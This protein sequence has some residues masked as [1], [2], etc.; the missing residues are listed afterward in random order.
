[1]QSAGIVAGVLSTIPVFVLYVN[2]D[3]VSILL[4]AVAALFI[5]ELD[6]LAFSTFF[7]E[8]SKSYSLLT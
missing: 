7:S 5:L 2:A 8:A 3:P 1:M 6:D 4:N